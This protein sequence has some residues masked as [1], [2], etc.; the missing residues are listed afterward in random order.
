MISHFN[1]SGSENSF[2]LDISTIQ[3][4][5]CGLKITGVVGDGSAEARFEASI[6]SRL[7]V[8]V[9]PVWEGG[10]DSLCQRYDKSLI[11]Q[12]LVSCLQDV[13]FCSEKIFDPDTGRWP[14]TII[15]LAKPSSPTLWP[16]A[17]IEKPHQH[18]CEM[19]ATWQR[20]ATC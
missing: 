14:Q 9:F 4:D 11:E 7:Q 1:L 3:Q 13:R 18:V 15:A 12:G 20:Q 10:T 6:A 16:A 17:R 8:Y 5:S 19:G 2:Y